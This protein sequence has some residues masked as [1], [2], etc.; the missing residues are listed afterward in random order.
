MVLL[1]VSCERL[2]G[3]NRKNFY[4]YDLFT[5]RAECAG[6]SIGSRQTTSPDA[7][8]ELAKY[9]SIKFKNSNIFD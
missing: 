3:I 5:V 4:G 9:G 8:E 2:S 1:R 6:S 7:A